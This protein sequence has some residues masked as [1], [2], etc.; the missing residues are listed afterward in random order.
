MSLSKRYLKSR[1]LCKVTFKL[2]GEKVG[3][4]RRVHLVG[5]F[6]GWNPK[7]TPMRKL[8]DGAFSAP[9]DLEAGRPYEY[10]YLLDQK[11]WENDEAADAYRPHPYGD[12]ENCVVDLSDRS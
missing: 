9:L 6:N 7:A 2:P 12:G 11:Q 3:G 10:R 8:K 4:A 1:P 5:E